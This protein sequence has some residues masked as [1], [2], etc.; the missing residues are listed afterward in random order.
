MD[1]LQQISN[2][3]LSDWLKHSNTSET[4]DLF[5]FTLV[6]KRHQ[7]LKDCRR[8]SWTI[9]KHGL[10]W[11][12]TSS[13]ENTKK[14]MFQNVHAIPCK[15]QL[16]HISTNYAKFQ[17]RIQFFTSIITSH[18]EIANDRSRVA[19]TYGHRGGEGQIAWQSQKGGSEHVPKLL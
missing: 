13:D 6:M 2:V 5:I 17:S 7:L 3:W 14:H 4:S 12:R 10:S 11:E 16:C 9:H 1:S 18:V 15:F 19:H 8:K